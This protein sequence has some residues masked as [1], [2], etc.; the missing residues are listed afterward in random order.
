M[1][2]FMQGGK[3]T[4][5]DIGR[6]RTILNEMK[7]IKTVDTDKTPSTQDRFESFYNEGVKICNRNSMK[8]R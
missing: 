4:K 7:Y 1:C 5:V 3:M 2:E 8:V 6:L